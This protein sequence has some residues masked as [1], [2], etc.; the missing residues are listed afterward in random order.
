LTGFRSCWIDQSAIPAPTIIKPIATFPFV[1]PKK[2]SDETPGCWACAEARGS[3][4]RS[5]TLA[6][7][8]VVSEVFGELDDESAIAGGAQTLTPSRTISAVAA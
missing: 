5:F 3:L 7:D 8:N 2:L 4:R 1:E 6:A